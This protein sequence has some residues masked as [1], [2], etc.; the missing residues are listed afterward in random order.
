MN[1]LK[2][3]LISVFPRAYEAVTSLTG[4]T[5]KG[6]AQGVDV[7]RW[8]GWFRPE[9]ATQRID[10]AA[11]KLTDGFNY[12]DSKANEMWSGVKQVE[13]RGAYHYQRSG[14]S[15]LA[16]ANYFLDVASKYDHHFFALDVEIYNNSLNDSFWADMYRIIHHWTEQAPSKKIV[17]YSNR[18]LFVDFIYPRIKAIYGGTGLTWLV[19]NVNIWYAQ[20]WN[21]PSV[22][23]DPALPTWMKTW[24]FWQITAS[25]F[26]GANWGVQSKEVDVDVFNGT[27]EQMRAWLGISTQ[28]PV[29][30]DPPPVVVDPPP[31]SIE[32][33]TEEQ[34][35]NAEV[36]VNTKLNIRN[37]PVVTDASRTGFYVFNGN[38][39]QGRL[40][41]GNGYVWLKIDA[42]SYPELHENWVAVRS[43]DGLAK[44][45]TL[46]NAGSV[47]TPEPPPISTLPAGRF[48]ARGLHDYETEVWMFKPRSL[49][50]STDGLK[51]SA[52]YP[53]MIPLK[54][55]EG[56]KMTQ[57]VQWLW[58]NQLLLT[59]FGH[60]NFKSL[61]FAQRD[62]AVRA[63]ASLTSS[64]RAFTNH[65]G[66]DP[67]EGRRDY[68]RDLNLDGEY[69]QMFEV[70][71][72]GN[73]FELTS[74]REHSYL[75][76]RWY[77]IKTLDP[78]KVGDYK[79]WS[80]ATHPEVFHVATNSTPF[81]NNGAWIVDPFPQLANVGYPGRDVIYPLFSSGGINYVE[82]SR[83]KL[84]T[85][86]DPYP[87]KAY[88]P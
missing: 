77:E 71:T 74:T 62:A 41:T 49:F 3:Q 32:P 78:L 66:T 21:E 56:T 13:M 85:D 83:V 34:L 30:P 72:G 33:E 68:I 69:P 76:K 73:V 39:F 29:E 24:R 4:V 54:K 70:A 82:V 31:V 8:Q 75:G 86:G 7:S 80:R 51:D 84:M 87:P 65:A 47:I 61:T 67:D 11:Q 60:T 58:F 43:Q 27:P 9:T 42:P 45:I 63:W 36:I 18:Y 50:S 6:R 22:D 17:L 59:M 26:A 16:Q 12:T 53:E 38:E 44:F 14:V 25:Y 1:I 37:Y 40:W 79:T 81:K 55:R 35:W 64:A 20:Y 23:K 57:G 5:P 88:N 15:W 10:F 19:D 2:R 48:F 52:G 28:P 46:T